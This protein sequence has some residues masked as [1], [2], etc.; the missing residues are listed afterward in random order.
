MRELGKLLVAPDVT[1]VIEPGQVARAMNDAW[2]MGNS[3]QLDVAQ[4]GLSA[5]KRET[6][7]LPR[8][9]DQHK[10]GGALE[11]AVRAS[12][13]YGIIGNPHRE[14]RKKYRQ[15]M[16]E[17]SARANRELT[18]A[19]LWIPDENRE[20]LWNAF[21]DHL[22]GF[23]QEWLANRAGALAVARVAAA[24]MQQGLS[25]RYPHVAVDAR[26]KV[27]LF[28]EVRERR[29]LA[30]QIKSCK[31]GFEY[32][33]WDNHHG[34]L[35]SSMAKDDVIIPYF[36]RVGARLNAPDLIWPPV[37]KG[38]KRIIKLHV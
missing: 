36:M 37:L 3:R 38:V 2:W 14:E 5:F 13:R 15:L 30:V 33:P 11:A 12:Y 16:I 35:L 32:R 4:L 18:Q 21:W 19:L 34:Q 27:D 29:Y 7:K 26:Q 9:L 17:G 20:E 22:T 28:C 6:I 23:N 25:V 10:A 8:E 1:D 31:Y 24:F